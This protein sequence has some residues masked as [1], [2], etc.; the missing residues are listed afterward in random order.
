MRKLVLALALATTMVSCTETTTTETTKT[1]ES[2]RLNK[3]VDSFKQ[4]KLEKLKELEIKRLEE[5]KKESNIWFS[6]HYVDEFGEP[7]PEGYISNV[8]Y[9]K[10]FMSNT[11]TTNSKLNVKF[12]ITS[13]KDFSIQLY[14]Y[15][16]TTP[17]K[18]YGRYNESYNV[19]IKAGDTKIK[20]DG[21][22]YAD[23]ISF[24]EK[25]S[26]KIHNLLLKHEKLSFLITEQKNRSSK[27]TFTID[28]TNDYIGTYNK[29]TKK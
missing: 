13:E 6:S 4:V 27:Y 21:T 26:K 7:T 8:D 10:G 29:F 9:I 17:I 2:A 11:A 14:E 24:D 20:M 16:G 3:L 28:N 19:L 15:A 22:N 23:R 25:N 18:I 1:T 12:L 5:E